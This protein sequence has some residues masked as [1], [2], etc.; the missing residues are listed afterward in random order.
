MK[1]KQVIPK[2]QVKILLKALTCYKEHIEDNEKETE[3]NEKETEENYSL[4]YDIIVLK[5]LLNYETSIEIEEEEPKGFSFKHGI[6]FPE[7]TGHEPTKVVDTKEL[8]QMVSDM[9]LTINDLNETIENY[10]SMD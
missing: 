2:D 3:D 4:L 1:I 6:D 7:Y 8:R 5:G 9:K 10:T